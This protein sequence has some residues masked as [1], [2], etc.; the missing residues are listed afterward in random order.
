[1]VGVDLI[2]K[3]MTKATPKSVGLPETGSGLDTPVRFVKGV[4]EARSAQLARLNIFVV[5]DLLFNLPRRYEDRTTFTT[6]GNLEPGQAAGFEAV[7][8]VCGWVRPKFGKS[9]Y[10]TV[11]E[12]V[13]GQV[14]ARWYGATYLKDLFKRGQKVSVFGKPLRQSGQLVIMHPEFE[15]IR[16]GR[17]GGSDKGRILPVYRLTEQLSLGV[18][19]KIVGNALQK[20]AEDVVEM[21]PN[22]MRDRLRLPSRIDALWQVHE[23]K[24][25]VAAE[26]GRQR[27]VFDELL[28]IQLVIAARKHFMEKVVKGYTHRINSD[29]LHTYKQSLPFELTVAQQRV[30]TEIQEDMARDQPMHRLLQGDVGSGKTVVAACA[31]LEAVANDFQ[32]A[33]MVPTEILARQHFSNLSR[34]LEPFDIRC[35]LITKDLSVKTRREVL[36]GIKSGRYQ[37]VIGTHALIQERVAFKHLS[38]VVIDE[39][40][41]F[42]VRQRG[43]LYEKGKHPDVLVMTATPIPRTLAMTVYGDL[44]ISLLDE[45]PKSRKEVVTRVINDEQLPKAYE[46]IRDQVAAGRQAFLVYPLI[47]ESDVLELKAAET[48]FNELAAGAF[49]GLRVGLLHGR[50]DGATKVKIMNRF[51]DGALDI[52][53]STT[54]VE[55]GVDV[56]NA[57]VMLVGS[58]ERFGLAQLHQLRGRIGR[59]AHKSYCI[60]QGEPGSKEAWQRLQVMA[61]TTDGFKI[62]EADLNIRG[63]G[64]LLGPEQS[65]TPGLR[66]ANPLTDQKILMAARDE[67]FRIFES[68]VDFKEGEWVF[69]KGEMKALYEEVRKY[70]KV[71]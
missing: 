27:L 6:I 21:L 58:A 4:G 61:Q 1:M 35:A 20:Y 14:R 18:M 11:F 50:L 57:S 12:D 54:V 44:D 8:S 25:L 68:G 38:M 24:T 31:L 23:P 66:L 32:G 69:L 19:R 53:V 51:R 70:L 71:G 42:G 55:V 10:E 39:Q 64:N 63:M 22:E 65:G 33:L 3:K 45:R 67:A 40:H 49:N 15:I 62:A 46:F 13:T 30:I 17:G 7:I 9:Y 56:P 2:K 34:A 43:V 28:L 59:G 52:L 29:L 37:I 36:S 5:Q 48:M 60:L 47:S 41:K 16:E 26:I